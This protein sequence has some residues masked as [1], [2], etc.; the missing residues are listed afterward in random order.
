MFK[1]LFTI[2]LHFDK[3]ATILTIFS[4][5]VLMIDWYTLVT[6]GSKAIDRILLYLVL[7]L[8]LI[9]FVLR[10]SPVAYGFTFGEWKA[11]L[12]LT[13]IGMAISTPI[14]WWAVQ[15]PNMQ[16]YYAYALSPLTPLLTFADLIGWEFL[17]RGLLLFGYARAFGANALWLH[18]VPFAF[19]HLG[20]PPLETL[21]TLFGGFIFG[22]VA[23]RTKS[24]IYPFLIHWYIFTLIVVLA[25]NAG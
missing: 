14:I 1:S 24:F 9:I 11:G 6:T 25:G 2:K 15:S 8:L 13:L 20:K 7:S 19:A 4:T 22:L 10:K 23:W 17:F 18:S 3:E 12:A 21:S 5:I 16:A